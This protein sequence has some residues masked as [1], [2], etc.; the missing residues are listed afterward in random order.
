MK[1]KISLFNIISSLCLQF[2][3]IISGFIIPK[4]VLDNFG[5]DVNGLISSLKQFL[6][7]ITIVEGGVSG[8]VVASLYKPI[9]N[10]D[11]KKMSSII[12]TASLFYKKIGFIYLIY[13]LILAIVYPL[14]FN[15]TFSFSYVFILTFVLSITMFI[16]YMFALSYRCLLVADKKIYFTSFVQII[17][18]ILNTLIT[19]IVSYLYP[20]IHIIKLFSGLVFLIQPILFN[21]YI[22]KHYSI[23]N[24]VKVDNSLIKDRWNG[25]AINIASFIHNSTDISV[26]TIFTNLKDVSVYSIYS[27]VTL[28]IKQL[29]VSV[30][31]AI[32]PTIGQAYAKKDHEDLFLKLNLYEYIVNFL[33]FFVF[34]ISILLITPFVL[35]YTKGLSDANYNQPLFGI[36][37]IVSEVIYLIKLPHLNLAYSANKFKEITKPAFAEAIINI[38]ISVILV[39]YFGLVGVT[40]GTIVAMLYRLVFHI[41]YTKK[42]I[43]RNQWVFYK[44]IIIFLIVS[45]VGIFICYTCFP[46]VNLSILIW[47]TYAFIY[48]FIFLI[49][50]GIISF[51]FFREELS[52]FKKYLLGKKKAHK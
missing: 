41:Y 47:I 18:I 3:T 33:V 42:I 16:Q 2:V 31:S 38:I 7:Y 34:S 9:L 48:S 44:K 27:I 37:L 21:R 30:A 23:S 25:F 1:N 22:D 32:T 17:I 12:K 24:D 6:S 51:I 20:N 11:N 19:V 4:I 14:L 8:I 39:Y 35:L 28:G 43:N 29:I 50:F 52:F 15:S 36:L 40:I 45:L 13:T 10:N 46:I 49:L 26:L 5:S